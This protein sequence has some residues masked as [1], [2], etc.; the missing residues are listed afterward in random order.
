MANFLV[1]AFGKNIV[2][3][4]RRLIHN[5]PMKPYLKRK[6]VEGVIFD[7]WIS[8]RDGRDWYDRQA[9]DPVWMELA[10]MRDHMIVPGDVVLE[11]GGHHGCTAIVLGSWVGVTGRVIT[12]EAL[13]RNCA[14]IDRNLKQ[15]NLQNVQLEKKAV[16]AQ[17]ETVFMNDASN[18][19][20]DYSRRGVAVEVV[21]LDD[22]IAVKP[23]VLKID[24][25]GFEL[26]VLEGAT[27]VLAL[28]P[29]IELELHTLDLPRYNAS[30]EKIFKAIDPSRYQTWVQWDD[31]SEPELYDFKQPIKT[32]V[33]LFFL[34]L[35]KG[36]S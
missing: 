8:D 30:I 5:R 4:V 14:I 3:M 18:S 17:P 27:G 21:R 20:V 12:F 9:T 35:N 23:T 29:K 11:C 34:P 15:N 16:G 24:V 2:R 28:H 26:Q 33:H 13:P 36:S 25:E 1:P 10:F 22:Y 6:N 31:V 32:R 19:S 7:F